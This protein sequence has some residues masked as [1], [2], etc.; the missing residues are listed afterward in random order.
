[1]SK[2]IPKFIGKV[3]N[4][5]VILEEQEQYENYLQDRKSVV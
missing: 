3:E 5:K 4:G 2:V 1:M